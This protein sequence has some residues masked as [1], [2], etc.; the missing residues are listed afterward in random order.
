[1][2]ALRK[3]S[4]E[5]LVC[6]LPFIQQVDKLCVACLAGKQRRTP[7]PQQAQWWVERTLELVH[8]DICG[9]ISPAT[10]G[11]MPTSCCWL[12]ITVISCG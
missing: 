1:M 5:E 2:P 7:F 8:G 3:M 10:P 6:G 9:L 4:Q 12:M 11:A